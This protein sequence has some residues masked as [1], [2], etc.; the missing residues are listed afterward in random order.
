MEFFAQIGCTHVMV[1]MP[2]GGV[3]NAEFKQRF[4]VIGAAIANSSNPRMVFGVWS[5]GFARSWTWAA[6]VGGTYWRMAS[7]IYDGWGSVLR[8]FD[9]AYSVPD[10]DRYTAPGQY[11]FLDQLVVG[12]VPGRPGS[13]YGPGLSPDETRAHFTM[14]VMAASPLMTANDVRNMSNLTASTLTNPEVLAV[15]KDPLSKMATR[16]D[17]GGGAH[18]LAMAEICPANFPACQEDGSC[19]HCVSNIS[20]YGKPLHDNSTAVM[21][22]NRGGTAA[23]TQLQLVDVNVGASITEQYAVRDLWQR[24]SLGTAT[25][26]L[27]LD[28]PAHGVRFLRLAPLAPV[29]CPAGWAPHAGG[30]WANLDPC[31]DCPHDHQN[32]TA[33][34]CAAKCT[35]TPTCAAFEVYTGPDDPGGGACFL[36]VGGLKPPFTANADCLTCTKSA[37]GGGTGGAARRPASQGFTIGNGTFL[38]D[39]APMRLFGGSLQH[40]RIPDQHWEHRLALARAMGL[41]AVQTLI[42]WWLMEPTPGAFVVDGQTDIV[43]FARLCQAHGLKIVLRPGPFI[44]DGPDFGGMPWWLASTRVRT[45]DP[46]FLNRVTIFY[47]KLFALLRAQRLTAD[48]GG[49]IIMAQVRCNRGSP[50]ATRLPRLHHIAYHCCDAIGICFDRRGSALFLRPRRI[51]KHDGTV[52]LA[53][54]CTLRLSPSPSLPR[55]ARSTTNTA[56]LARTRPTW[57]SYGICG[58]LGS[59]PAS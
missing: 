28:V 47:T 3:T 14:W 27:T 11:S 43:R 21:I 13:A 19:R 6:D 49:P 33:A 7:D 22:L 4:A 24:A 29:A 38:L 23:T 5:G 35:A 51:S 39:G 48:L 9:V 17:V 53:C 45:A 44:C 15:H 42:P 54:M 2:G 26:S 16:I 1:D 30:F 50:F 57:A 41:N 55:I 59:A 46:E 34:R 37:G 10:I 52:R 12:D 25:G 40:F 18:E 56:S 8:Q 32:G 31:N 36:F 58:G 20:I